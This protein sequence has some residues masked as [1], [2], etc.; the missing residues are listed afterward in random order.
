MNYLATSCGELTLVRLWRIKSLL[1]PT[2][3]E[4]M[5]CWSTGV[6]VNKIGPPKW[7]YSSNP[8]L[9]HSITPTRPP[10]LSES[11]GGQVSH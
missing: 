2:S 9:H 6:V 10:R 7:I 11:D 1:V 3:S 4:G 8:I 5:E